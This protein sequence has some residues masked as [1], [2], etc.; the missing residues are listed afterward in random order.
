M[1]KMK[2]LKILPMK[3]TKKKKI[4]EEIWSPKLSKEV[5]KK[6]NFRMMTKFNL[7]RFKNIKKIIKEDIY[8]QMIFS[9]TSLKKLMVKPQK[10]IYNQ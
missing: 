8:H 9:L 5:V 2:K 1:N 10:N 4:E 3:S 6:K 7:T